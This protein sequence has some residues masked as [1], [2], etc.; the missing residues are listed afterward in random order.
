MMAL[1]TFFVNETWL[2]AQGDEEKT[3]EL[4]SSGLDVK[5]FP[6]QSRSTDLGI[7]TIYKSILSSNI[8]FKTNS[9]FTHTSFE[10]AQVS[11]TLL[12]NTL[13]F[14][15]LYRNSTNRLFFY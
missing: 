4:A 5:S 6:P 14:L 13:S 2:S 12:H 3:V 15:C 1:T 8:T 9:D 11:S 10:V 7:A